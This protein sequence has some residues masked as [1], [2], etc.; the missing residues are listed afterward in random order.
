MEEK[1]DEVEDVEEGILMTGGQLGGSMVGQR[2]VLCTWAVGEVWERFSQDHAQMVRRSLTATGLALPIDGS[3]DSEISVK[4]LDTSLL[5]AAL[6]D[7]HEGALTTNDE[8]EV[9]EKEELN[10]AFD[11]LDG[12]YLVGEA[13]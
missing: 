9:E 8:D 4:G 10:I 12:E 1:V 2:R 6:E 5:I 7:W 11:E 3:R 13:E